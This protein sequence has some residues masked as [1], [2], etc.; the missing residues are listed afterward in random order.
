MRFGHLILAFVFVGA[1]AGGW[2]ALGADK[3]N[4]VME[5]PYLWLE[6]IHGAKPM[7]WVKAQNA[8]SLGILKAD[9]DYQNDYDSLLKVMDAT[10]RIPYGS[11]DHQ[12]VFNFWQDAQ[13][14]KGVWRRTAI[15]DYANAQ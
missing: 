10:D 9:P 15:A 1:V 5:D 8:K 2:S 6:D 3:M 4:H 12:Y 7:E 14:P 13:H 11:L